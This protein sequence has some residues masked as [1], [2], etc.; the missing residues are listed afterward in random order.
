MNTFRS[1]ILFATLTLTADFAVSASLPPTNLD[2]DAAFQSLKDGNQRFISGKPASCTN[3]PAKRARLTESQAPN[4]IVL[5]CSDSRVP[6]EQIFDQG[7]GK[8]FTVRV[9]GNVLNSDAIASIEYAISH[10]GSHLIVVLGHDSC[11]AVSAA[12]TTPPGKSAGSPNLDHLLAEIRTNLGSTRTTAT[13]LEESIKK[14]VS[15][16]TSSLSKRSKIVHDALASEQV[17]IVQG[18]YDLHS[19]EVTFWD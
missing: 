9:A 1:L 6:P 4:A 7:L 5:S 15:V 14:N 19:G 11:G 8:V 13:S 18:I 2:A 16:V 17:R 3:A 10:L 12:V